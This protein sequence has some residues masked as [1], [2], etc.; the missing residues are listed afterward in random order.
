MKSLQVELV[1]SDLKP[2]AAPPTF[3]HRGTAPISIG[4]RLSS[5]YAAVD[6]GTGADTSMWHNVRA[7]FDR[8][9]GRRRRRMTRRRPNSGSEAAQGRGNRGTGLEGDARVSRPSAGHTCSGVLFPRDSGETFVWCSQASMRSAVGHHV[10][11]SR[12][13][14][15]CSVSD[16]AG[17]VA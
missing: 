13:G 9:H 11:V 4:H 14:S 5:R 2:Q 1:K 17:S 6:T 10:L 16:C 7:S 12:C 3:E 15:L 8:V